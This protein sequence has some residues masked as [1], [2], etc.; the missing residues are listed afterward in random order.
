MSSYS[1]KDFKT[2]LAIAIKVKLHKK[3]ISQEEFASQMGYSTS[4]VS[5]W[6]T[7]GDVP[8]ETFMMISKYFEFKNFSD[9]FI[10]VERFL[11]E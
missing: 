9:F 6:V 7:K 5:R 10:Y 2:A 4:A 8:F 3:G 11:D 1:I